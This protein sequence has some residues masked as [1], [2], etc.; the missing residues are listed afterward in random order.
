MALISEILNQV[1]SDDGKSLR[2]E[3]IGGTGGISMNFLYGATN[4][5]Q[6][7]GNSGDV[8]LNTESG[9]LFKKEDAWIL[10]SNLKG[11]QGEQGIQ[12][13]QGTP[14]VGIVDITSDDTE[15][16]FHLSDGSTKAIPWPIQEG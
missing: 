16:T 10:V 5:T 1:L 9:D 13:E 2:V 7:V 8:Y 12:G 3:C 15:I 6:E 14:G 11:P 4:P